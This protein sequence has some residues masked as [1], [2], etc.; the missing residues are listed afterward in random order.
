MAE[1]WDI[2]DE[3][4]KKTG[5]LAEKDVYKF[6]K[7]EYHIVVTGIIFNTKREILISKRARWKKYG[8]LWECNSGSILAG[9]TSL[10]G[11]IRELKEELG[12]E[13]SEKEAI[14]LKEAKRDKKVPDFKDLWIFERNIPIE[15]ITFPDGEATEAKWVTIEQFM[16][17]Y[18]N[19]EIV[20]TIDFGEEEYKMAV[21]ILKKKKIE[22]YYSNTELDI[23]KKNVKYF[24]ENIKTYPGKA[25]DIGCGAG[26]E[27]VYLIKKG[28]NVIS[29][30]KENVEERISK[31]LST[32]ELKRFKFQKQNFESL[33]LEKNNLI[34]A[35]YCLPFCNKNNFKELWN[36]INDSI[37]KDGYFV[38]NFFG[39][40]DEW[41][42][43]KEEMTF[44]TKEQVIELFKDFE[45][46]EFKE[47]EKDD[48][49]GLG[50][51]KHWH[52]FNV[53]AKKK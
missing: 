8:G 7:R 15:K 53:I 12:I 5:K 23:P 13:F 37:L 50:K 41:K 17:M 34:V 29:I 46:I 9:E 35:N 49:T 36:K 6:K 39:N 18:D 32:E 26:N 31:R 25:I 52:I 19:N 38:G 44:L 30:D 24:I 40:N 2:Y 10:E 42:S 4:R 47:V 1:L 3:N 33:E 21:E 48:F 16:N 22:K 28:W 51:M 20:P 45:I 43:R 14:Y 11:I 27:T